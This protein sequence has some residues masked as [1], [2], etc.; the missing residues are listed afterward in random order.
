MNNKDTYSKEFN[1][2]DFIISVSPIIDNNSKWS[3]Q[4]SIDI[5]SSEKNPLNDPD[6]KNLFHLCKM[7][8][9]LIPVMENDEELL[10]RL[11][12]YATDFEKEHRKKDKLIISGTKGNVV[13]LNWKSKTEGSA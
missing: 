10:E 6:Y 1:K 8:C 7:M 3:G 9:S 4:I 11:D 13:T 5:A 12:E 2:Q